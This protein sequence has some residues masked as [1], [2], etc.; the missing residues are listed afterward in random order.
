MLI[1]SYFHTGLIAYG[2]GLLVTNIA[3]CVFRSPQPALM[4]INPILLCAC[5]IKVCM[6]TDTCL[7]IS[8][9]PFFFTLRTHIFTTKRQW[10]YGVLC[11][12][13]KKGKERERSEPL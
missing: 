1:D 8:F 6:E 5:L 2:I 9:K 7:Y 3:L 11:F 12:I 13:I 10:D 4:W